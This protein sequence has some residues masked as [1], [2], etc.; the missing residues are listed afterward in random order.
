MLKAVHE[1]N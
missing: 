1:A